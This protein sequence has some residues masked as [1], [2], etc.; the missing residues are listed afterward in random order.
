MVCD[1]CSQN[2]KYLD[3]SR[4]GAPKR[5]CLRCFAPPPTAAAEEPRG[6]PAP[7]PQQMVAARLPEVSQ[8]EAVA[9]LADFT[10]D[11]PWE[12]NMLFLQGA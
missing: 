2:R 1:P 3:S 5:V 9:A 10:F 8:E 4:T 6:R 7:S 12:F 11:G